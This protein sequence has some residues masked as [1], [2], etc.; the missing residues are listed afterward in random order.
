MSVRGHSIVRLL[1][2]LPEHLGVDEDLIHRGRVLDR[3]YIEARYPNGFPEGYPAEFFDRRYL[4]SLEIRWVDREELLKSLKEK[5][6]ELKEKRPD[7]LK[8]VLF[9]SF[10]KG[11]YTPESDIDFLVVV[12]KSNKPFLKR[13][14]DFSPFFENLPFDVNPVVYTEDEIANMDRDDF[15]KEVFEKAIEL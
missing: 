5:V 10:A 3:Y 1:R 8:V 12:R 6:S 7:V 14:D 11:N 4:G 9:G 15:L 2:G 13:R